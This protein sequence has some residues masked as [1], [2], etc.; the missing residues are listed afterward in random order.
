M[1]SIRITSRP[2]IIIEK[3]E[4]N[5]HRGINPLPP[6]QKHHPHLSCQAAPLHWQ[7]VQAPRLPPPLFR[8]SPFYIGFSRIPPTKKSD[9]SVNHQNIKCFHP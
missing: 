2:I 3:T 5:V 8:Q 7:T 1:Q 4:R 6:P 9:F